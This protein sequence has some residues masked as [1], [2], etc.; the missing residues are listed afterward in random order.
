MRTSLFFIRTLGPF[1]T[2]RHKTP[3]GYRD[4][5]AHRVQRFFRQITQERL[6]DTLRIPDEMSATSSSESSKEAHDPGFAVIAG[7]QL[8]Q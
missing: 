8:G 4:V 6:A 7:L 1:H 2:K 3:S 5:A